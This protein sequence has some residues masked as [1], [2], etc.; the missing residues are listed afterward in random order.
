MV[1]ARD[2]EPSRDWQDV[3]VEVGRRIAPWPT[4]GRRRRSVIDEALADPARSVR[5]PRPTT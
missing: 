4:P 2:T 3:A 5:R 1:M